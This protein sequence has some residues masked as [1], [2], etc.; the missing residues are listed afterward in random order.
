MILTFRYLFFQFLGSA[1]PL[2]YQESSPL[3]QVA[4]RL[5]QVAELFVHFLEEL[6]DHLSRIHALQRVAHTLLRGPRT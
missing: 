1:F 2:P 6:R 4:S 3:L 5:L